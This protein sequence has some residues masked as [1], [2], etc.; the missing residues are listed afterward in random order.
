MII[1]FVERMKGVLEKCKLIWNV[2]RSPLPEKNMQEEQA[3][4][5]PE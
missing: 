3:S 2:A 5:P 1:L 4:I